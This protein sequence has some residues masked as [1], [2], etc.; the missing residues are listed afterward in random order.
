MSFPMLENPSGDFCYYNGNKIVL[1]SAEGKTLLEPVSD[2]VYYESIKIRD[3]VLMFFE[4]HMLRLLQS[5][6]AKE[7]FPLDTDVLFDDAMKM[8]REAEPPVS[9]GNIR[10]VITNKGKLIHF[11]NVV[12]PPDD[13]SSKGI[14]ASLMHWERLDPQVKIFHSDYKSAV[15]VKFEEPTPFGP[16]FE[17][18]L[19]DGKGQITE[20]SRSNFFVLYHGVVYSPPEA[21]ILIGITRRYVLLSV[22]KAGLVYKEALFSLEDLVRMRDESKTHT[23]SV[24]LFITSSPFDILPVRSVGDE[25]FLSAQNE[26]LAR[27]SE[28]YQ[29]IV[30]HYIQTHPADQ[31]QPEYDSLSDC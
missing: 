16:A 24:A 12:T 17:V 23:D 19:T 7:K 14:A 26:D 8:L 21:L 2:V 30:T 4:N 3:G 13:S 31:V 18:L 20:G 10:I 29:G 9:D 1:S 28:I 27:I 15:A 22:R 5:I 6:E 25:V 11:S